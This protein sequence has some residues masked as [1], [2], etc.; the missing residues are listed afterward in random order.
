MRLLWLQQPL[1]RSS[2]CRCA[3][4]ATTLASKVRSKRAVQV[5][6]ATAKQTS[7][8]QLHVAQCAGD[9]AE[10]AQSALLLHHPPAINI[11]D[12]LFPFFLLQ[13]EVEAVL[14]RKWT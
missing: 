2:G 13:V 6:L 14:L 7:A 1:P 12:G 11:V 3:A 10:R 5:P 9:G 4:A 8:A